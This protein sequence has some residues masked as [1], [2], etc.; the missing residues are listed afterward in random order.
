[1]PCLLE[2]NSSGYQTVPLARTVQHTYPVSQGWR[3]DLLGG[4]RVTSPAGETVDVPSRKAQALLA[5]LALH[6]GRAIPRQQ[7]AADLWPAS[8]S[9]MQR[10]SLRQAIAQLN[11]A[12]QPIA[13]VSGDRDTCQLAL[14]PWECDALARLDGH[15]VETEGELLPE[16]PEAVFDS[17]RVDCADY[18]PTGDWA[19]A[20]TGAVRLLQWAMA[21]DPARSLDLL[22]A[23]RELIPSLP[24][25]LLED[26]LSA[27]LTAAAADH[28]HYLWGQVQIAI[29]QMWRG[30]SDRG[31]ESAK[32]ALSATN[33]EE[34]PDD[35]TA[36]AFA[37]AMALIFVGRFDR[38]HTLIHDAIRI[39]NSRGLEPCARRMRHADAHCFAYSGD[40]D[41]AIAILT[42]LESATDDVS[43][44]TIRRVHRAAYLSLAGRTEEAGELLRS[45]RK[46]VPGVV[47]ARLES[48]FLGAEAYLLLREGRIDE[49]RAIF[50]RLRE[51]SHELGT[52]II[53]IQAT[54]NLAVIAVDESAR[55]GFLAAATEMRKRHRLPLLPLD[56]IRL[57]EIRQPGDVS[58]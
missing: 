1:M 21:Q 9:A 29:V 39:L 44:I 27:A 7:L 31:L 19:S 40:L 42:E 24:L 54:E 3:I 18:S 53:V 33:P 41:A 2:N 26:A 8:P 55:Q 28:R 12:F 51:F 57:G 36:A 16:M 25:N 23:A 43:M 13:C 48:Q 4:F 56:R 37:A 11:K 30:E 32:R 52:P 49:A 34:N 22:H 45:A 58:R 20:V 46:S 15:A 10:Q 17:W 14:R 38:A 47:G 35:W 5:L 50:A 6:R